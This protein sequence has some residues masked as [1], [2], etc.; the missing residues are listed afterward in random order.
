MSVVVL[1]TAMRL[2]MGSG[3]AESVKRRTALGRSKS[4]GEVSLAGR[5]QKQDGGDGVIKNF[6]DHAAN[7]R[8]YL[9]WVRTGV[10][11]MAFGFLVEKF[12]IFLS[13]IAKALHK[14]SSAH[15]GMHAA[16]VL[17]MGLVVL[18]ILMMVIATIRF[19]WTGREI[20][21]EAIRD[22]A[23]PTPYVVMVGALAVMG[24]MLLVYLAHVSAH[25]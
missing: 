1:E 24:V 23:S 7:E 5:R 19:A 4:A 10:A 6:S 13:Y 17:G 2:Y 25:P 11:V 3:G 14:V 22:R 18:G 20:D 15:S 16:Q 21:E 8:T 12:D 9:A